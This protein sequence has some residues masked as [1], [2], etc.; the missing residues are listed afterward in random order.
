MGKPH[1]EAVLAGQI[2][3]LLKAQV[4]RWLRLRPDVLAFNSAP[5]HDG[6]TGALY[7]VLKRRGG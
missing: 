3:Q 5:R 7:V 4:D 2:L 1:R 6:G